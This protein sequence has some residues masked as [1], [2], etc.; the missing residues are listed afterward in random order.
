MTASLEL[1]SLGDLFGIAKRDTP[2][3]FL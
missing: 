3:F 2:E 1:G